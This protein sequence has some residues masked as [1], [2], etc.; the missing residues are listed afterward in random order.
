MTTILVWGVGILLSSFIVFGWSTNKE[1]QDKD[2]NAQNGENEQESSSDGIIVSHSTRDFNQFAKFCLVLSMYSISMQIIMGIVMIA[3]GFPI[4]IFNGTSIHGMVFNA[5]ILIAEIL[6]FKKNRIGLIT[7]ITL[8]I[9]RFFLLVPMGTGSYSYF[10][11]INLV[12]LFQDFGFFAIAMCFKKEGV[13]GWELMLLSE[14]QDTTSTMKTSIGDSTLEQKCIERTIDNAEEVSESKQNQNILLQNTTKENM[15]EILEEQSPL[16]IVPI[17]EDHKEANARKIKKTNSP[18]RKIKGSIAALA[19]LSLVFIGSGFSL[20]LSI[21]SKDYPNYITRIDDKIKYYFSIPNNRLA[22]DLISMHQKAKAEELT[23]LCKD[24]TC[25]AL[26]VNPNKIEILKLIAN[27]FCACASISDDSDEYAVIYY[28]DGVE[29]LILR[30][31]CEQ[32]EKDNSKAKV[33][34]YAD[35]DYYHIPLDKKKEFLEK[36]PKGVYY[37]SE[38]S[39][40]YHKA[41]EVLNRVLSKSPS[42]IESLRSLA[43][44][45][46]VTNELQKA[47]RTAEQLL[48]NNSNDDVGLNIMCIKYYN[49]KEWNNLLEWCEKSRNIDTDNPAWVECTYLYAKALYETGDKFDAMKFYA[50]AERKDPYHWLHAE[51][52]AL[53][54]RPCTIL[55][56]SVGNERKDGFVINK[57]GETI[58]EGNTCYLTP[59]IKVTPKRM[60]V[61]NLDVKLYKNGEL[62][63]NTTTSPIGY[64]YSTTVRISGPEKQTIEVGGWGSDELGTWDRGNYR[65]EI[66]WKGNML[67]SQSFK[68]Y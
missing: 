7:L 60:G 39:W 52:E 25:N 18:K 42:D 1:E 43:F 45:Y 37:I 12:H 54:G 22:K 15:A 24:Y 53:G 66:W 10:L 38:E 51:L 28:L 8:F 33:Q 55:S 40:N 14:I 64:T 26:D 30:E 44:S 34:M 6:T 50:E 19:I 62:R 13:S 48:Y 23:E 2:S 58:Y 29:H 47:Y 5:A 17:P 57:P 65:F 36:F 61:F 3:M 56:L 49:L 32:F 31:N 46:V 16:I 27:A 68:I 41:I 67:Y 59:F 21:N 20:I 63:R 4:S 9:A 35:G 11:G